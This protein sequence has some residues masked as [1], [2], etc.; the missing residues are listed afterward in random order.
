MSDVHLQLI[1]SLYKHT[2][3]SFV[4]V[5]ATAGVTIKSEISY[6][7]FRFLTNEVVNQES[8][9]VRPS[10]SNCLIVDMASTFLARSLIN[11]EIKKIHC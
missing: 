8:Y 1:C 4:P 5:L 9:F 7:P 2:E 10:F 3:Q 11:Y 6:T